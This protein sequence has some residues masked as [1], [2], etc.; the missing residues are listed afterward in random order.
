[1]SARGDD[2]RRVTE[3]PQPSGTVTLVFTD[4]EGST[5]LLEELGTDGYRDALVEHRRIVR[6]ACSRY[7]GY[8]VDYEGDAFFYAFSSAQAAVRAVSEAMSGLAEGPIRIRVGIH[9]GEPALDPPKYVG[10][11]VHRAAR[12]MASAHGGQVVLS[13]SA[14]ALLPPGT[15]RLRDLGEHRLKD[16]SAP[17]R[18]HQLWVDGLPTEFPPLKT[19][20]RS[21]LPVPATPFLGRRQELDSVAALLA[22]PHVRL[23]TLTGPGGAGKTRLALQAAAETADTFPDGTYWAPLASVRD[24]A[25]ALT[26]MADAVSAKADAGSTLEEA[27]AAGLSGRRPLLVVD[28]A[29]HLLPALAA[30][31]TTF[32]RAVPTATLLVTSRERLRLDGEHVYAVPGMEVREATTLFLERARA[33]GAGLGE[34]AA[35]A[36]LCERLDHLPLALELAAARTT[37]FA[38]E[39]LL[40]R[41]DE[42]LDLLRGGRDTDPRQETL[43]ATIGWSHD[44]LDEHEQCLFRRFGVFVGGCTFEAAEHIAEADP[45]T[46]QSLL[47]KSLLRKADSTG[48]ARYW[49]LETVREY[50]LE[51]LAEV[52]ELH[53]LGQRHSDFYVALVREANATMMGPEQWTCLATLDGDAANWRSAL[54]RLLETEDFERAASMMANLADYWWFRGRA[55]EGF[56]LLRSLLERGVSDPTVRASALRGAVDLAYQL[57]LRD[58]EKR[59]LDESLELFEQLGDADGVAITLANYVWWASAMGD[60]YTATQYAGRAIAAAQHS[61]TPWIRAYTLV[62]AGEMASLRNEPSEATRLLDEAHRF[63]REARNP[64]IVLLVQAALGWHEVVMGDYEAARASLVEARALADP[65]DRELVSGVEVNLGLVDTLAGRPAS[66]VVH[67][68]ACL[69]TVPAGSRRVVGEALLGIAGLVASSHPEAAV[70]LWSTSVALHE[71]C[72]APLGPVLG[73]IETEMLSRL[74]SS[75][76]ESAFARL[77]ATGHALTMP[78]AVDLGIAEAARIA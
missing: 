70:Q 50:A 35:V 77:W 14:V 57:D 61:D 10:L 13:P 44:L 16:L 71:S 48:A 23:L 1:M 42:R 29:E 11:D 45:D 20:H 73:R 65:Q 15:S 63:A 22:Q 4:I 75:L 32:R 54:H 74:Q 33:V 7:E 60:E 6:D 62:S 43:R 2:N 72:R 3:V 40:A 25:L 37:L 49:M 27:L 19:L 18:L 5:R 67:Y 46:L 78:E 51:Q 55:D 24:P 26:S 64:R 28:N 8:E 76:D 69:E 38:P 34:T 39:Q 53:E 58:V 47:D 52:G 56:P 59:Y 21:N 68:Q 41:L 66:A 17:I 30:A 12:V 31:L 36:Q 9:A